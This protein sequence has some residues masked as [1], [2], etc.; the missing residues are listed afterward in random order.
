[1]GQK[2]GKKMGVKDEQ[3]GTRNGSDPNPKWLKGKRT[4]MAYCKISEQVFEKWIS[5]G[6]PAVILEGSYR[7]H[8]NNLDHFLGHISKSGDKTY[9]PDAK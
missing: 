5:I 8:T 3:N 6:L 7:A 9:N 4:I 2:D 1:M